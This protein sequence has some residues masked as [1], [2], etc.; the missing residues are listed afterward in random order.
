MSKNARV[1]K[2]NANRENR[3]IA[4]V[5]NKKAHQSA[6]LKLTVN[7]LELKNTDN[8]CHQQRLK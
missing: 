6:L 7:L 2:F 3:F 1:F 8:L 5:L 4:R